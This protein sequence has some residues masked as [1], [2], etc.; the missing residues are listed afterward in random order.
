M[1]RTVLLE[2]NISIQYLQTTRIVLFRTII[3][4]M[5][6]I[7]IV[8]IIIMFRRIMNEKCLVSDPYSFKT[9]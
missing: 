1:L 4:M 7:I 5:M 9:S 6:M 3:M 2:C 8:I